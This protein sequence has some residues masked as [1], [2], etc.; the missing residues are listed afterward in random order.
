MKNAYS[1]YI[2]NLKKSADW[3]ILS[4][5][6]GNGGSCGYFSPLS[7][8]SKPYPETTGYLIPTLI[9]LSDFLNDPKYIYAA[10]ELGEW[11]LRIQSKEGFWHSGLHKNVSQ[12][13]ASPSVFNTGQILKGMTALFHSSQETKFLEAADKGA[14]WLVSKMGNDGLWP[15]KDYKANKTPSYYSHVA[16]PILEVWKVTKNLEQK[17][18]A[19]TFLDAVLKR[20]LD[21]GVIKKW[22]FSD[23]GPA[24]THTIA[25]TIRGFQESGKLLGNYSKYAKPMED[26]LEVFIRK[27]ELTNGKLPGEFDNNFRGNKRFVCLTGNAQLAI[28]ILLMEKE[29]PDLRLVNSAAKLIDFISSTQ[30]SISFIKSISGAVAGSYPIWGRY[31]FM[32]YPNWSAKYYCDALMLMIAR[33]ESE[34]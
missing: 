6:K 8:W 32:R 29:N 10:N 12:I 9:R 23:D 33:L 4:I 7:G 1:G 22:G 17:K 34:R 15:S 31:M 3:L 19:E 11:L 16:W 5:K 14:N 18:A 24:F 2:D 27:S 26:C 25:Y 21:N 13:E 30:L 20:K 28:S